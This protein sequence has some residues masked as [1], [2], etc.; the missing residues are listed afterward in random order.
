VHDDS[1]QTNL[2]WVALKNVSPYSETIRL[3]KVFKWKYIA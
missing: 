1:Y 2:E 3:K